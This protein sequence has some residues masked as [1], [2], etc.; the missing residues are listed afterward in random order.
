MHSLASCC[1]HKGANDAFTPYQRL[2]RTR[3][4]SCLGNNIN[5]QSSH[6]T[7]HVD[8][9]S[10][11]S[12]CITIDSIDLQPNHS[13]CNAA[14]SSSR[15]KNRI[16]PHRNAGS[17]SK[18]PNCD[19]AGGAVPSHIDPMP[20]ST[21]NCTFINISTSTEKEAQKGIIHG[22][23]DANT[24]LVK[25]GIVGDSETGKTSFMAKYG[26][27][28]MKN[29]EKESEGV[30]L[31]QKLCKLT[32]VN[33]ALHI[34]DLGGQWPCGNKLIMVCKDAAAIFIMFDLTRRS[35]LYSVKKWFLRAKECNKVAVFVVIGTK[36]DGF[37]QMPQD[38]QLAIIQEARCY[39]QA[40]GAPLFFSSVTHNINIHKI[41][42]VV[43]AKLFDLPCNI[44]QNLNL[45]EPIIEYQK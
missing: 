1:T 11:R 23:D 34:W 7:Y 21:D 2:H 9:A 17:Q 29:E 12:D 6:F 44:S 37:V 43:L 18:R 33:I 26:G 25:I 24:V 28:E 31:L 27:M 15:S 8:T 22:D 3:S 4:S 41:F 16:K 30:A 19:V 14:P 5:A 32:H 35:T 42:K 45:G 39:S 38:I 36:Y 20:H 10:P 40:M 13:D